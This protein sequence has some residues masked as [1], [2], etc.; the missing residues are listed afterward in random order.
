M[1]LGI[2]NTATCITRFEVPSGV[3][4]IGTGVARAPS[5]LTWLWAAR[6]KWTPKQVR[7]LNKHENQ[8]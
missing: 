3:F 6:Q 1:K 2:G 4:P 8:T 5:D 7:V